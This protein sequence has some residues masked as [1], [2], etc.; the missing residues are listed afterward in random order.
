[1][2]DNLTG[3]YRL[4]PLLT[5]LT[6]RD[7]TVAN[8]FVMA[9]M[10]REHSPGR[11]PGED[12]AAYYR[13]RAAGQVGLIVT[14]GVAIDDPAA[15]DTAAVPAMY[16]DAPL[17][18]WRRV[19]D[20]VDAAGGRIMPQL[21]HQGAM[22]DAA[23][24]PDPDVGP[25]RPS[26]ILGPLGKV[27]LADDHLVR[28]NVDTPPMTEEDIADVIAA[29]ARS[30]GHAAKLGFDGI[31]IHGGHGYVLDNFLWA[32]TNRRTD[33]WGGDAVQRT[34]FVVEVV[35]AI[36]AAIG[37]GLPILLRFSQFKMQDYLARL[38]DTPAELEAILGPIADAG[39]DI[40]DGSQRYFDTPA[41]D[42]S[43][44]NLGG[45]AKKL[46]GKLGM[47]VG[48]VGLDQGKRDHHI[49]SGS[50]ASDNLGKLVERFERGE[51]DLIGV[52]RSL[53]NDPDWVGKAIRGEPFLP[54]DSANLTRLT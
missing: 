22:R 46:T 27:S 32:G 41:F 4:A 40:F 2:T 24:S 8:R 39:V 35:R 54:F 34:T 38:A 6:V 17:A 44:L 11:V 49:D 26:G 13:R 51:F 53:L 25:R 37:D 45:W 3:R 43:P 10:T 20:E 42:G 50:G 23:T 47:V 36:R 9:P 31:A 21:W 48:G 15:V 16:G 5:P 52:G 28:L 30:A 1:M 7:L 12:V 33:R 14:E 19:I 29:Y 18:G